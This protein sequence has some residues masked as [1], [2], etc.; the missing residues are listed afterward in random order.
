M[1]SA[2]TIVMDVFVVVAVA[3]T[4]R[5]VVRFFGQLSSQQWGQTVVSVTNWFTMPFGVD[6][7]R[8]PYGGVFDIDAALTIVALLAIEWV[9]SI[10]RARV[11]V[12]KP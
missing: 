12:S 8:T 6:A 11:P 1:R 9:L 4:L 3:Q 2:I 10:L 7:I 5:L